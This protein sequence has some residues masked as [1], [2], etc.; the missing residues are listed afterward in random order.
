[1]RR[2]LTLYLLALAVMFGLG[3]RGLTQDRTFTMIDPPSSNGTMTFA[4]DINSAG[5]ISGAYVGVDARNHG[6]LRSIEGEFTT[7]DFPGANFT[8]TAGINDRGDA[9]GMYR[10]AGEPA[11]VRHGYFLSK[12]GEFTTIDPPDSARTTALGINDRGD[13]VGRYCTVEGCRATPRQDHG[14]LLRDGVFTTFDVPGAVATSAWKINSANQIAGGYEDTAGKSHVFLLSNDQFTTIDFPGAVDTAPGQDNGG[15]NTQGDV[16]CYYCDDAACANLHGFLVSDREVNSF[17]FPGA[18]STFA[19]GINS[20]QD[21]V[22]GYTDASNKTHGFL[23]N[24]REM[25][26]INSEVAA[27]SAQSRTDLQR[28]RN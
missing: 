6:Y 9:V 11:P 21:I 22:G 28:S 14:F 20:R 23:L 27:T 3:A 12:E 15:I 7:I 5:L 26:Q 2:H 19:F 17:D 25:N 1:M 24:G 4:T 18:L 16:V 10:L 8:R 13:I